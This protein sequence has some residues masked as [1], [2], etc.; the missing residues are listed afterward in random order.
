MG[1][2]VVD[3]GVCGLRADGRHTSG[4]GGGAKEREP[5]ALESCVGEQ[6]RGRHAMAHRKA[7]MN[8]SRLAQ[9]PCRD[10]DEGVSEAL[11]LP[12]HRLSRQRQLG[13]PGLEVVRES[14]TGQKGGIGRQ[15]SKSSP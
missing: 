1:E 6:D 10:I 5:S 12:A 7:D 14:R 2:P 15:S 4:V 13:K 9:D 8:L 3:R 11:P